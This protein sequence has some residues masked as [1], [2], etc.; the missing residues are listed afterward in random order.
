MHNSFGQFFFRNSYQLIVAA[1]LITISFFVDNYWAGNSSVKAVQKNLSTY[2][3]DQQE[4]YQ[5][6]IHDT[7]T[8]N[9][10]VTRNHDEEFLKKYISKHYFFYLYEQHDTGHFTLSFW[11]TQ[12]VVPNDE[13][14]LSDKNEGFVQLQNG[15]YAWQKFYV[16]NIASV[17]LIP[18]KWKYIIR[19]D[20]LQN[21]FVIGDGIE[22]NY[23]LT[24]TPNNWPVQ[25]I[26]GT[27]LFYLTQI[28]S[29]A[30][31][32]NNIVAIWLRIFAALVVLVFIHFC[33][34][35]L[36]LKNQLKNAILFLITTIITLRT[37]SYYL[38]IPLN[39]RQFELFD[40]TIYGSNW[41][42][43]SLG[44]LLINT[45]LFVWF[46]LFIYHH[47]QEKNIQ[48]K[49]RKT[50]EKW[51]YLL[52][53]VII[54]IGTTFTI[55]HIIRSMVADSQIS[56][57][58]INF[59]T[60]DLYS[61]IGFIVLCCMAMGYFFVTLIILFLLRPLF[62]KNFIQLY[63]CTAVVGLVFLTVN[64]SYSSIEF[65]LYMLVWLMGYIF[66]INSS[67]LKLVSNKLI[68]S[69]LI[70]WLFFFSISIV[71]II[72]AEN[73]LK[74]RRNREHYAE[75]LFTK[76]DPG[77]ETLIN[78]FL[79]D[80]SN[81]FLA[82]NFYRFKNDSAN[83]AL[84]DSIV[85][86]IFSG[87]SNK[88][89]TKIYTFDFDERPLFNSD[90]SS[91]KDLNF[92]INTQAKP[93]NTATDG[94]FYYEESYD[95]FSYIS[96]KNIIDPLGN[97]LGY[98]FIIAR[99]KIFKTDALY[100]ELF[101]K[102][103]SNSIENSPI[104]SFAVYNNL[105]LVNSHNEYT[106]ATTLDSTDVPLGSI[107]TIKRNGYDELW[108]K[109]GPDKIVIIAKEDN[110]LIEAITL[111]S[112]LFCAFLLVAALFWFLNILIVSRWGSN[113]LRYNWQMSIQNQ[114]HVTIIFIC[115]L[116]FLIIGVAT[117]LFFI[118]RYE[119][120]NK[121]KLSRTIRI[122]ENEVKSSF[123]ELSVANDVL[124]IYDE[125]YK[126]K[127]EKL[128]AKISEVHAVDINL[129]DVEGTLQVSSL[130]LPYNK[131][132]VSTR[133]DPLAFY[134]LNHK[135]EAQYFKEERIGKLSFVSNYL[136]VMDKAG[137]VYAYLN[138]PYF[139][140][141]SKLKQEISNFLVTIIN[142][143]A[144]IFL[145]AG[146]VALFIT[147]RITGSFTL[148]GNKMKEV[149][150]GKLNEPIEW[151]RN[152][153]IGILVKEYNKMMSKL[154][155]SAAMLA[156]SER[157]TAWREMARQV[158]HEIKNPLTPMKLSLQ[159]LQKAI[160]N[161]DQNVNE[162]SQNVAQTLV[163]QIEHLNQIAS[164]FSQFANIGNPKIEKFDLND[165]LKS[166]IRLHSA[167]DGGQ[168]MLQ[169]LDAKIMIEADK[170][171]I[172]RLFTNL[173]Q[174]AFQAV[175][176]DRM[177]DIKVIS[178]IENEK[179]ALVT[180][181]DNGTGIPDDI[182]AKIFTPN[183]TTKT[184]GTGLGLAMCKGIVEQAKGQIWF[185]TTTNKGTRFFVQIPSVVVNGLIDNG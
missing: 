51:F 75:I 132:I 90:S 96:K 103:Y 45:L 102:G 144:F 26:S 10:L 14:L 71:S 148:I 13:I 38:P 181:T 164:E 66:L 122:M 65:E 169:S 59:F 85:S 70:F 120:N 176:S 121:E 142:L 161:N 143:N 98:A 78:T 107:T 83:L 57:D 136:P 18:I 17:V 53:S 5:K 158:A 163:E 177:P 137:T 46:V 155:E 101:S 61:F 8:I 152:D 154:D 139:T 19:N 72:V 167:G 86:S 81:D 116:C 48:I 1:W 34:T 125:E 149:N 172:N 74:E 12:A 31:V 108:Y 159:Y 112:Y 114:I 7:V 35:F 64:L 127:L 123:S 39:F 41:V 79:A 56:F 185:D 141:Q 111:F 150:L 135:K 40:P 21:T 183:F 32:K 23:D 67:Y 82:N 115:V 109:A 178:K 89:D 92:I 27:P 16:N 106:F 162:L 28:G 3:H 47:L 80:L 100:P 117:I 15:Y 104:Y 20:Y 42:L 157:E 22:A 52:L 170:T 55:G 91:Y 24:T 58:V 44:D 179:Y 175:P 118:N 29:A 133:M 97:L 6:L 128:V 33:A 138:I 94:L 165:S 171:Q 99:P 50:F 2:L 9:K 145:I 76:S 84:K 160:K 63:V 134:H 151:K 25:S 168:I 68:S 60:L 4:D 124:K 43:R 88:Y 146:I 184:S 147:N 77:G 130:P 11:N 166:L 110:F 182:Q 180:I 119:S 156:K 140:S 174:N 131:G 87:Y 153:E 113:R 54:L 62:P 36:A 129:Y 126:A 105:Q 95:R 30:L 93:T 49:P 69:K 37:A 173:I 73:K